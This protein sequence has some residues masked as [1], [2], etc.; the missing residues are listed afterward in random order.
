MM[1]VDSFD[2]IINQP[3]VAILAVGRLRTIPEWMDGEWL[4]KWAISVTLSV[5]HRVADGADGASF[6]ADL[7]DAITNWELMT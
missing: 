7:Q 2:A 6:L 3:E 5:D 1:G 4:P